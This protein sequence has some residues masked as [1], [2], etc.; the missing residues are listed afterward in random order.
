MRRLSL[1]QGGLTMLKLSFKTAERKFVLN[2]GNQILVKSGQ[3]QGVFIASLP[4]FP[5][6]GIKINFS[7]GDRQ[8]IIALYKSECAKRNIQ[9]RFDVV[10][11]LFIMTGMCEKSDMIIQCSYNYGVPKS[12]QIMTVMVHNGSV[13]VSD[14]FDCSMGAV[15][16]LKKKAGIILSKKVGTTSIHFADGAHKCLVTVDSSGQAIVLSRC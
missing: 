5:A 12:Q 15:T 7:A 2:D 8:K 9:C 3:G 16:E 4:N 6:N 10:K 13:Q 1:N 14:Y 11:E